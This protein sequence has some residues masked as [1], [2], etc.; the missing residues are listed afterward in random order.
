MENGEQFNEYLIEARKDNNINY[1]IR[2]GFL[3]RRK[4]AT[5]RPPLS[6]VNIT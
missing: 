5:Y 1:L 3:S 4:K 6:I 2:S